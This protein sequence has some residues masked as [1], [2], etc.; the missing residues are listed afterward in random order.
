MCMWLKAFWACHQSWIERFLR[1]PCIFVLSVNGKL[2]CT[3]CWLKCNF[4]IFPSVSK[5]FTQEMSRIFLR[6]LNVTT[7]YCTISNADNLD[8]DVATTHHEVTSFQLMQTIISRLSSVALTPFQMSHYTI[9]DW[10]FNGIVIIIILTC[11][12]CSSVR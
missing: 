10:N 12:K 5:I 9:S 11:L 8:L 6:W 3:H 1:M 2:N 7:L 4:C